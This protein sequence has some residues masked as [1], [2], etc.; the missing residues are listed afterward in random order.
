MTDQLAA[1][2]NVVQ[3]D[4]SGGESSQTAA[5]G[6]QAKVNEATTV[7]TTVGQT[8]SSQGAARDT[9]ALTATSNLDAETSV[10]TKIAMNSDKQTS[11]QTKSIGFGATTKPDEKSEATSTLQVDEL[12]QGG[13]TTSLAFTNRKALNEEL[14]ALSERS[15]VFSDTGTTRNN[16]YGLVRSRDG[17]NLEG[18]FTK[19][20]K[21]SE[22]EVSDTNIFGLTGDV[23]D[24][25]AVQGGIEK[26]KVQNLDKTQTD[27]L[28]LSTGVGYVFKDV[29]AARDKL[30]ASTKLEWRMDRGVEDKDQYVIYNA[31]EGKITDNAS[32]M[33][34]FEY[35][36]TKNKTTGKTDQR[37]KE[38]ILGAAYR[39]VSVDNLNLIGRY[40]YKENA[41]PIGQSDAQG[42]DKSR[43][44]VLAADVV[45]D[46]NDTWQMVE[47]FAFRINEEKI[48]GFEFNK[49]HTWLMVHRLNYRLDRQWTLGA[50]YRRLTQEEAQDSKQGFLV[51]AIRQINDNTQLGVGWNF[52][53]FSDDLT[54]LGY[55]TTGPFIRMSGAFYDR[56]PEEKARAKA[57][58]LD[59]RISQWAWKM[60]H[61]ELSKNNSPVVKE[62]NTM[63]SLAQQ[64]Q[65]KG[66]LKGSQLIFKNIIAAGQMMF[67]EASEYVRS[68]VVFEDQLKAYHQTAA[69]YYKQGEY[70]KARKIWEKVVDEASKNMLQ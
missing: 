12:A 28:V 54:K 19:A 30:K 64:A 5:L 31:L 43:M 17:K 68:Q 40:T 57:K 45:Y 21:D 25:V 56:T 38:I 23:N 14:A 61:K 49:T 26:G 44:Q 34:K 62:L 36:Q 37:H 32:V 1:T 67:D 52:T 63:F 65:S 27:R 2:A 59:E 50:E 15:F 18:S 58:W 51:E 47:K 22:T 46:F 8:T 10:N 41:G 24:R 66:D 13:K 33:A 16:K 7:E 35:S 42:V 48:T 29:V 20:Q 11:E 4:A 53:Q 3:S 69:D 60:V 9:L 55:T 70:L 39:P 6:V